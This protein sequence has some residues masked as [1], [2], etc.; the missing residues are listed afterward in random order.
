MVERLDPQ[1]AAMLLGDPDKI[2]AYGL[3]VAER[4]AVHKNTR[5][6]NGSGNMTESVPSKILALSTKQSGVLDDDV[7]EAFEMLR[8]G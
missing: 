6:R 3:L 4:S 7:R 2:R 1:S 8:D 5:Q